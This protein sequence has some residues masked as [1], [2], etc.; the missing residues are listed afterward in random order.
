MSTNSLQ[1]VEAMLNES[2]VQD[3]K[4]MFKREAIALPMTDF[5]DD[6]ADVLA[7]FHAGKK[8]VVSAL[9]SEELSIN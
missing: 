2:G 9:P 5:Q 1:A 6:V 7:K 3:V 8:T 4:F